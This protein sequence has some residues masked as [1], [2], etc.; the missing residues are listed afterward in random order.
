MQIYKYIFLIAWI[1]TLLLTP[2]SIFAQ[3]NILSEKA[4]QNTQSLLNKQKLKSAAKNVAD[5]AKDPI[6]EGRRIDVFDYD[7]NS[8]NIDVSN[9][10]GGALKEDELN[11][12]DNTV[13]IDTLNF[14]RRS[15]SVKN[16]DM[17]MYQKGLPSP[18]INTQVYEENK[19]FDLEMK[20]FGWHPYWMKN[21]Y[22]SYNFS[23][24]TAVAYYSYEIK[25]EDGSYRSIHDWQTT[26]LIQMAHD[27]SCKVLFS[28]SN[29][30][31]KDNITFL[32]N[33]S[34][35]RNCISTL[36]SLVQARQ[37]DGIHIDFE[38][39]PKS[40]RDAFTN[41][42]LDLGFQ[43]KAIL[44]DAWLSISLPALDIDKIYQISQIN[45]QIDLFV[46]MGY[47][48]YG[49]NTQTAGPIAS[50]N[51]GEHWWQFG[52]QR[53]VDEY[54]AAGID[55][56]KLLLT[57]PYYGGEWITNE[58]TFPSKSKKFYRY[59]MYRDIK[60]ASNVSKRPLEEPSSMSVYIGYQDGNNN[61]HQIWYDDTLSLAKKYAW[62]REKKLG[63]VGIWALGYDNGHTDLWEVLDR[64][65]AKKAPKTKKQNV[66]WWRSLFTRMMRILS[67]PQT[68]LQ[69]PRSLL[70]LFGFLTGTSLMGF[71][72]LYRYGYRFSKVFNIG[73]KGTVIVV[74]L[75]ILGLLIMMASNN[76][77]STPLVTAAYI[78]G[79]FIIG[80]IVFLLINRGS[81]SER[82]LP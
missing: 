50:M 15:L 8:D 34:A 39:V 72:V 52:L 46:M 25:P 62:I 63:G 61:Y 76:Y 66:G 79:G 45:S 32:D 4:K 60:N 40:H 57:F 65:F 1:I 27:D 53:G 54:L 67:N 30:G 19:D 49:A 22:E 5:E 7:P 17:F 51:G 10:G 73:I 35:Q 81:S 3:K 11:L 59:L 47:E 48:F 12:A 18:I 14:I 55:P 77:G 56:Q 16:R 70:S 29:L 64:K 28:V 23:L 26:D 21:A 6:I 80:A 20:V 2:A 36:I 69:N 38:G 71:F 44:P 68:L 75:V 42:I 43:L 41:F 82:D 31:E 33:R 58:L 74:L 24:L 13:F 9:P 37:A 78:V